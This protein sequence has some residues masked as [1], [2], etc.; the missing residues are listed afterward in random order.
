VVEYFAHAALGELRAAYISS[1]S[2]PSSEYQPLKEVL[3]DLALVGTGQAFQELQTRIQA[4]RQLASRRDTTQPS[5][6]HGLRDSTDQPATC[7]NS[8]NTLGFGD[9]MA[10]VARALL[11]LPTIVSR[12][13]SSLIPAEKQQ[14]HVDI[15]GS[16]PLTQ[17][18]PNYLGE[19]NTLQP[20]PGQ[21]SETGL[22]LPL[23]N[24]TCD[25]PIPTCEAI[26][27]VFLGLAHLDTTC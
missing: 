18:L 15:A 16:K 6:R 11:D 14:S 17:P 5:L 12:H 8:E 26:D 9:D 13:T 2:G 7:S 19:A 23:P 27:D 24:N 10:D 20:S 1:G 4:D 21:E 3:Y 22:Q 25:S